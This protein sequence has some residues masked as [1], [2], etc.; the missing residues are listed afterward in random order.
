MKKINSIRYKSIQSHLTSAIATGI[1]FFVGLQLFLLFLPDNPLTLL[2]ILWLTLYVFLIAIFTAV[3]FGYRN[4]ES[5]KMR[6]EDIST[7]IMNMSRGNL[8]KQIETSE[9]DEVGIISYELNQLT[10]KIQSQ[11][12]SL[13]KLADEKTTLANETHRLAVIE[14]RQRLARDLHDAVS[15]QLFALSMMSSAAVRL[16]EQN[17]EKAKD[18][19]KSIAE[20]AGN[21]QVEMRALLLHLRPVHLSG[22]SL[23]E[24]IEK[25]IT[26][27][28]ERC[29]LD[30][31]VSFDELPTLTKGTEDHLFRIIQEALANILRH[32]D[33]SKVRVE[34]L[35]RTTYL[36]L[37]IA[38][39]GK[40]FDILEDKKASYGLTTM[41][42]RCEE[43]GGSMSVKSK[44]AEGTYLD[45][46]I[47]LK[48]EE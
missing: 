8:S 11:V 22:D 47:P 17:P 19:L 34:L 13:Q 26:E 46:R 9:N 41:R 43:I 25:L 6:L 5:I 10:Q 36:N 7:F 12:N 18:Q 28:K 48:E 32:A 2:Q 40:G 23:Q 45:I 38:D 20:M 24:G 27:L 35:N 30:F 15:Q 42:E 44:K 14:E 3:Y 29:T 1:F 37:H 4:S 21:A 39:N 31:S 16:L 33:A